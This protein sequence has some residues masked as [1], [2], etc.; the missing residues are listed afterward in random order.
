MV[1]VLVSAILCV[2]YCYGAAAQGQQQGTPKPPDA[3]SSPALI[4]D[5]VKQVFKP[6]HLA[7]IIIPEGERVG[8]IID[9]ENGTL[10]AGVDDCFPG[11][12]PRQ[13]PGQL[14]AI[15]IFSEQD[16]A[17]ALGVGEVVGASG[18][19]VAGVTFILDFTEVRVDRVSQ[20]QLR[21]SLKQNSRE[22]ECNTV[23]PYLDSSPEVA[24][25]KS[26]QR[27]KIKIAEANNPGGENL[28]VSDKPP[29]LILG[30]VF[31]AR[32]VVHVATSK[33]LAGDAK[34][35]IGER[36]MGR[37]GL[38]SSF[39]V[40]VDGNDKAS[41][42]VDLIGHNL[43]PVALAPAFVVTAS[44]QLANGR[45]EY[46]FAAIN[47]GSVQKDI[48][49][50]ERNKSDWNTQFAIFQQFLGGSLSRKEVAVFN[51]PDALQNVLGLGPGP[52]S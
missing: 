40:K 33:T 27:G 36:I 48:L 18:E 49:V 42:S 12:Q 5:T 51:R 23:R 47:P 52:P 41:S 44:R 45:T 50:A 15:A 13:T 24:Q 17:A 2:T 10:I 11:L 32:R 43:V 26:P 20:Y 9:V 1:R 29:P 7:P 37:L 22:R 39:K 14:P 4:L 31:Y 8:D 30:M 28:I 25:A 38:G 3:P 6:F 35:S 19:A 16:L 34:L 46:K 21:H